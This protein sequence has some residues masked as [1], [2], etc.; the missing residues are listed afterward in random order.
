MEFKLTADQT[1]KYIEEYIAKWQYQKDNKTTPETIC[2]A[3]L[4]AFA[5]VKQLLLKE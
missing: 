2:N 1:G 3:Y 4:G 5:A